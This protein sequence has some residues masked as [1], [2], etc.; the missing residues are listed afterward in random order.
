MGLGPCGKQVRYGDGN[1][2]STAIGRLIA[3]QFILALQ[4]LG[5]QAPPET[6]AQIPNND[7][8]VLAVLRAQ[9]VNQPKVAT[10]P[11]L[12]LHFAAKVALTG[13]RQDLPA[14]D[15]NQKLQQPLQVKTANA[16]TVLPKGSKLLQLAPPVLP[17]TVL[18][19]GAFVSDQHLSQT[20]VDRVVS[21]CS[22]SG[23]PRVGISETQVWGVPWTEEDFVKQMVRFGHPSTLQS[24][25]YRQF[26]RRRWRS[27]RLWMR[28][29]GC[30]LGQQNLVT[31]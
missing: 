23:V 6:L 1:C 28:T 27:T 10:L 25:A 21:L 31:G 17:P 15:M 5:I 20:N 24:S 14:F 18:Q 8:A 13:F 4:P 22:S 12:I 2:L 26:S 29:K 16:P 30:Q 7:S 19:G 11:P 3:A 9:T